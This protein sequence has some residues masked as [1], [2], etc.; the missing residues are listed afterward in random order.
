MLE[1]P[2]RQ[3]Q[4]QLTAGPVKACHAITRHNR[5]QLAHWTIRVGLKVNG[6]VVCPD[7]QRSGNLSVYLTKVTTRLNDRRF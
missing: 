5:L 6:I 1:L 2:K 7:S 4:L 3:L